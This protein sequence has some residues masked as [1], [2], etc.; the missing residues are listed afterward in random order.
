MCDTLV[1][2]PASTR[3]NVTLFAKNSDRERT[4]VQLVETF[5]AAD[6]DSQVQMTCTY[7]TIPQAR[8]THAVLISRPFWMWGAEMGANERGVVIGNEA[9][10]ARIPPQEEES[11]LG[12]DLLRLGLERASTAAEAMH[13]IIELLERHGQGGNCGFRIPSFYHNSFLIADTT[14][15]YILETVGRDWVAE[16]VRNSR[17]ISNSLSVAK[18]PMAVSKGLDALIGQ[19]AWPAATVTGYADALADRNCDA[20]GRRRCARSTALLAGSGG[21]LTVGGMISILR[22][23]GPETERNISWRLKPSADRTVCMHAT[24]SEPRGQTVGS[25]VSELSGKGAVHWLTATAAPCTSIFKPLLPGIPVPYTAPTPR[26]ELKTGNLW[27]E[28]ERLHQAL[29]HTDDHVVVAIY[30]ERDALE[31]EFRQRIAVGLESGDASDQARLVTQCW[32]DAE[33]FERRWSLRLGSA[34]ERVD[35]GRSGSW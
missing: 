2:L 16:R 31:A 17:A 20:S 3:K 25:L 4:E 11:L 33:A 26:G 19:N 18:S 7:L 32:Q 13:V 8:H 34:T 12:M 1:A 24:D 14:E 30:V 22:D 5:P 28:H 29:M 23:H 21:D 6:H 9:V 35:C 27:S 15:A 10:F